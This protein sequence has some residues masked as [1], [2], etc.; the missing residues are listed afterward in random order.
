MAMHIV[1]TGTHKLDTWRGFPSLTS[2][3]EGL[4]ALVGAD[5]GADLGEAGRW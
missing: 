3:R 2:E 4:K 1:H 5:L